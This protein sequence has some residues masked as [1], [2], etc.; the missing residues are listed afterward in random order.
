MISIAID[1]PS[2]AGKSTMAKIIAKENG[3]IYLDTGAMY[4]AFALHVLNNNYSID[5]INNDIVKELYDSFSLDIQYVE[6]KQQMI[7]NNENVSNRIRTP[8]VSL[9]ASRI[10]TLP[11]VREY[12]VKMQ[13]EFAKN[14]NVVMDGRDIGSNVLKDADVKIFLTAAV[15]DRARRRFE[16]LRE[17]GNT[18]VTFEEVLEDMKLRDKIDSSRE[19]APLTKAE[20][21]VEINTT[22]LEIEQ[23]LELIRKVIKEKLC[24]F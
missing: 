17:K 7:L 9:A 3:F 2:G 23:S 19:I 12:F 4:R 16:E 14:K 21:A 8:E 20:D 5:E 6:D 15:E 11:A 13:R 24:G 18:E 22:G 1:G 10:A